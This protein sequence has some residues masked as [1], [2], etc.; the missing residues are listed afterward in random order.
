M[1]LRFHRSAA[2]ALTLGSAAPIAAS[3]VAAEHIAS[4]HQ[5]SPVAASSLRP[6]DLRIATIGYRLATARPELCPRLAPVSG[7]LLH[8]LGDYAPADRPELIEAGLNRG[9]GILSVVADSPAAHAGID[10][11]DI[12]LAVNGQSLESPVAIAAIADVKARR[13]AIEASEGKLLQM[14]ER[15]T[16]RLTLLRGGTTIQRMLTP[17]QGCLLRIRL[18]VSNQRQAVAN[19]DYVIVA[20]GLLALARNDDELAFVIGHEMGHVQL[21]HRDLLQAARI[22]RNGALR[23]FGKNGE[24]VQRTEAEADAFGGRLAIAAGYDLSRGAEIL[25]RLDPA[26]TL[27]GLFRT[28][29]DPQVRIRALRAM[30]ASQGTLPPTR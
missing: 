17:V 10:A 24:L 14:L 25:A 13:A 3:P 27:F 6:D 16:A 4:V 29:A 18:A 9:P 8:H 23:G 12:L 2:L 19:G 7:L 30:A 20:T 11:G 1:T 21:R 22:P 5:A 28:H 26:I 15:G